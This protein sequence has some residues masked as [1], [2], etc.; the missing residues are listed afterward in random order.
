[1]DIVEPSLV[2]ILFIYDFCPFESLTKIIKTL[3]YK[4]FDGLW[5]KFRGLDLPF[6]NL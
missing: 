3:K 4:L 2:N 1:M 6:R 5:T